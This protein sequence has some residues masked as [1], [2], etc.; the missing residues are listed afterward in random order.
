MK[1]IILV[2]CVSFNVRCHVFDVAVV[3]F[4]PDR[5]VHSTIN[6][7]SN[8]RRALCITTVSITSNHN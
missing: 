7:V 1:C 5:L 2:V 3:S 4:I 8:Q 6:D